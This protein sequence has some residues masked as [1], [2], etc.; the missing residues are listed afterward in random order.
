VIRIE[1]RENQYADHPYSVIVLDDGNP[2]VQAVV[3]RNRR[4][5]DGKTPAAAQTREART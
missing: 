1:E 2:M 3:E 5:D 4:R